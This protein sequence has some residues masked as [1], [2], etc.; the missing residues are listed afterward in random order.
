M[1]DPADLRN[2]VYAMGVIALY[3]GAR[4]A[5]WG[6]DASRERSAVASRDERDSPE[7]NRLQRADDARE[8]RSPA[9][10]YFVSFVCFAMAAGI[11][12]NLLAP[13]TAYACMC[14]ALVVRCITDQ[15]A[16]E[17]APRRRSALLGRVRHVDPILLI[18]I[19]FAALSSL[20]L[21]PA[22]LDSA[23]RATAIPVALCVAGMIVV[24]W[25]IAS[26]PPLLSGDDLEA[27]EI[28]D[29][30]TRV[31][32]TGNT[33]VASISPAI[34]YILFFG[35][36]RGTTLVPTIYLA[37]TIVWVGLLVWK[38]LYARHL[39]RTPLAS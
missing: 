32:R 8:R 2:G 10:R 37:P 29:S 19:G 15:V 26:A 24:A 23:S 25:R 36:P 5:W 34:A 13:T 20:V 30:E 18:W 3:V 31:T 28:V 1:F 6:V 33:C 27:E 14:L 4:F 21:L 7:R 9:A 12:S 22:L 16:E 17:R 11:F 38:T 39:A 35:L